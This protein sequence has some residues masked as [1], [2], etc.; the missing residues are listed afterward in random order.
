VALVE[1]L[2]GQA[3]RA[4][5]PAPSLHPT[6]HLTHASVPPPQTP[7]H[8]HTQVLPSDQIQKGMGALVESLIGQAFLP[9]ACANPTPHL[10][11]APPLP[12]HV[13]PPPPPS[14]NRCCRL[15]RS[16]RYG[17]HWWRAWCWV[18]VSLFHMAPSTTHISCTP[19]PLARPQPPPPPHTP[20]QVLP[21]DQIQKGMGALVESLDDLRLD[22]P[23]AV[24]LLSL[25]IARGVVS[26]GC[27]GRWARG[28]GT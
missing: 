20:T 14:K 3:L 6:T 22:V 25:F 18:H 17:W 28:G 19:A 13:Y 7:T 5:V 1:S 10:S 26:W 21:S 27:P 9:V 15:T 12:P 8:T 23:D 4:C 16:R 11:Y 2:I 24:E